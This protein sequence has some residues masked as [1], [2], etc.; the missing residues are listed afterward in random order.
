MK[1]F[2]LLV[3]YSALA[4]IQ[5]NAANITSGSG[6]SKP[7]D[8]PG[9]QP[10]EYT[11]TASANMPNGG[12]T[13]GGGA[14]I[15]GSQAT[16]DATPS[17]G[18]VFVN[19][20]EYGSQV[21]TDATYEVKVDADRQLMANFVKQVAITVT[22]IPSNGGYTSGANTYP[23]G[24]MVKLKAYPNN[25]WVFSKWTENGVTVSTSESYSTY[26]DASHNLVA[27]FVSTVGLPLYQVPSFKIYPNP[28]DGQLIIENSTHSQAFISE[29]TLVNNTGQCVYRK[30]D[31]FSDKMVIDISGS[32]PGRYNLRISLTDGKFNNYKIMLTD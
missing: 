26:A 14:Y 16:L 17:P 30:N 7:P 28:T 15:T 6:N 23:S 13:S 21:S 4:V 32:A 5:I 22:S 8:G 19:W 29:I 12:Y 10:S 3:F 31:N 20:T 9:S 27:N 24:E 2:L 11:I 25:G 18:F 1:N